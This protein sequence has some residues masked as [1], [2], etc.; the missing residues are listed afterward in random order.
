M[1]KIEDIVASLTP[2]ERKQH[3]QLIKECR[4]REASF[5]ELGKA[6]SENVEKLIETTN[7]ILLDI[8]RFYKLSLELQ[9][10]CRDIKD[11]MLKDS[12]ESIPDDK[13][14]HA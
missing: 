10:Y 5:I 9:E 6:L 2:Q 14:Y 7:K 4:E 11:D 13:F 12:I 3:Q 1:K 8:N